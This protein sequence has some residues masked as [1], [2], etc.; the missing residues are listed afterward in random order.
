[1][2]SG[3]PVLGTRRGVA[4]RGDLAP[5]VGALGDT[6]E[7]LVALRAR[8]RRDRSRRRAGSRVERHF[9]HHVMADGYVR[10]FRHFL[11]DGRAARRG[12]RPAS[13]L[14]LTGT[15]ARDAQQLDR[16]GACRCARPAR[17]GR[18]PAATC[19]AHARSC[20]A[21]AVSVRRSSTVSRDQ[22]LR[23]LRGSAGA[24]RA[25][26]STTWGT[27]IAASFEEPA[28]APGPSCASD[29]PPHDRLMAT[30]APA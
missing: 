7:E 5:T 20:S 2:A 27:P 28:I 6:V 16:A 12:A 11:A 13:G 1:M 8:A 21:S 14:G 18:P 25:P 4:A 30:D 22:D 10:M 19:S 17:A 3:T 29:S 26:S 15:G 24:G 9:T 23:A